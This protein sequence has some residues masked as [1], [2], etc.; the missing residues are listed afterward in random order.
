MLVTEFVGGGSLDLRLY[1]QA[2]AATL[3]PAE[4][5]RVAAGVAAGLVHIHSKPLVHRDL[6]PANVLL[7]ADLT[8]KVADVGLARALHG[9]QA[10]MTGTAAAGTPVYM[11]PEQWKGERLSAKTDVYA[12]GVMLNEM[13]TDTRPWEGAGNMMAIGR[14]VSRGDR[15]PVASGAVGQLVARCW[16]AEPAERLTMEQA[17][18][19]LA[20]L[21]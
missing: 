11:A 14:K 9:T 12:F 3:T 15:P 8:A 4:R 18:R 2:G 21:A 10:H 5:R 19:E 20:Q 6:K 16:A 13:E 7:A 17:M 1:P